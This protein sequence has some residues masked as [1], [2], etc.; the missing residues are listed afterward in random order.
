VR[1]TG[2][3]R[4]T[5]RRYLRDEE[6]IRYKPRPP[7][8]AKLD[9]FK[10]YV[11]ERLRAAAPERIPASVLLMELRERGYTGGYT[12]LKMFAASLRPKEPAAPII[13][14]ETEPGEQMQV[15]WAV[16]RR[17]TNR[18]SV[19]VATLGWSRA[20]YVEFV[21]DERVETLIAAHENAFLVFSGVPHAVLYDNMRTVVV[22]RH[23]YGRGRHR[24][25]P[26]FL[27]FARHYGFRPRLCAPYR[28]Q[29]KGKVERFIRYLR[30][31]FCIPL[32]SRLAQEGLIVDRETANLAVRRWLREVANAR[33][34]G[35]T[36]EIPAERLMRERP[37]L[38]P[39]PLPYGG[40][41]VRAVQARPEPGPIVGIQHPLSLYDVFAGA[42]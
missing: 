15:D 24:F 35:T 12:M 19:F 26:G 22:E 18:L 39:T 40:R 9:P 38:Q 36:G 2:I 34:H 33:I 11:V 31:S 41:T 4:N 8:P 20:S 29:T 42:S 13:R 27:D 7:R 37:H 3:S 28:A 16:I 10:A 23:G 5:V 14:F 30:Q 6:A 25:H 21:T 32:A 1:D 17:S